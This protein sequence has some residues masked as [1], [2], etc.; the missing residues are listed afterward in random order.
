MFYAEGRWLSVFVLARLVKITCMHSIPRLLVFLAFT[1]II[2]SGCEKHEKSTDQKKV[3]FDL[4]GFIDNQIVY[5]S[6]KKPPLIKHAMLDGTQEDHTIKVVD[7]KKELE[8]FM[9]ADINKP[10]YNNSYSVDS[11]RANFLHYS[12]KTTEKLPVRDLQIQLD[13]V[14]RVPVFVKALLQSE[15]KIYKSEKT[16]QLHCT[17][18]N[19]LW[20]ISGYAV[21][22]Y[23]KLVLM[24]KRE[25]NITAE[26]GL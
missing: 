2:L 20:G 13:S 17:K 5:L 3:Y 26:I 14:T 10:A 22:G 21:T 23:Q 8:L 6:E 25:F 11:S 16:I 7:W 9:Q 12:L 1:F 19:N 18:K 24:D 4:K 15:N